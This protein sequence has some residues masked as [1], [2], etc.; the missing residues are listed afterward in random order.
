[1]A[2]REAPRMWVDSSDH[3][4]REDDREACFIRIDGA[5]AG[6][7]MTRGLDDSV[8]EV[9]E[10]FV[11]RRHRRLGAGRIMVTGDDE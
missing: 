9:S 7:S 5:L 4:F 2:K 11:L 1:M 8:R 10:F 6:F 3:Y